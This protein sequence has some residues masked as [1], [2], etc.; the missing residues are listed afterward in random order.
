MGATL[1]SG[2]R[3]MAAILSLMLTDRATFC[4][5]VSQAECRAMRSQY[6]WL[7]LG[8]K[9]R[10]SAV[11]GSVSLL[12]FCSLL[13]AEKVTTRRGLRIAKVIGKH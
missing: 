11:A 6:C 9:G 12:L 7:F 1:Y 5:G 13:K 8:S 2:K 10:L 3:D 4:S